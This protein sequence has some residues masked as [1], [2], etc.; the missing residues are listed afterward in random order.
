[1]VTDTTII[2]LNKKA[3]LTPEWKHTPSKA[4]SLALQSEAGREQHREMRCFQKEKKATEHE[5]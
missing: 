3:R 1:M 5:G 2:F 4:H